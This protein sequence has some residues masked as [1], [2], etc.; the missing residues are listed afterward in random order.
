MSRNLTVKMNVK[1]RLWFKLMF[2]LLMFLHSIRI[3]KDEYVL[4]TVNYALSVGAFKYKMDNG[5]WRNLKMDQK[6]E[7][8]D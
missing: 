1:Q 8:A 4:S 5:K 3:L 6:F 2:K 7:F